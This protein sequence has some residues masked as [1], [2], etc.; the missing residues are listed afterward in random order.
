[1]RNR[2]TKFEDNIQANDADE[3]K[4]QWKTEGGPEFNHLRAM[5]WLAIE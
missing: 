1:M 3:R 5:R 2:D 4:G